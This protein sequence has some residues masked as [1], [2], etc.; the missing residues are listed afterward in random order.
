MANDG[1]ILFVLES[2]KGFVTTPK[3]AFGKRDHLITFAASDARKSKNTTSKP[4]FD[5]ADKFFDV[6]PEVPRTVKNI[7]AFCKVSSPT[8][9]SGML[10]Y[11]LTPSRCSRRSAHASATLRQLVRP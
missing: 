2:N 8:V 1:A 3:F 7:L 4:F 11:C 10:L 5:V 9:A 6:N